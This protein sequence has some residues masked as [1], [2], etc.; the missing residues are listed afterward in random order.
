MN[1]IFALFIAGI[2]VGV[3]RAFRPQDWGLPKN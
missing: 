2:I 3:W 1:G